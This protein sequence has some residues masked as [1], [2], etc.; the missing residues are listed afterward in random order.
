MC[1]KGFVCNFYGFVC[2]AEGGVQ[3]YVS[4]WDVYILWLLNWVY[5]RIQTPVHRARLV[6]SRCKDARLVQSRPCICKAGAFMLQKDMATTI[7]VLAGEGGAN[8]EHTLYTGLGLAPA[9]QMH[10]LL[11]TSLT[12]F[13]LDLGV[14][15]HYFRYKIIKFGITILALVNRFCL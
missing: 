6:Q 7:M 10:G 14:F 15:M 11:C 9:L 2:R 1:T 12:P 8:L 13:S 3:T 4:P 5:F